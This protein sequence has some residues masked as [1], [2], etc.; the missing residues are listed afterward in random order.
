M[1]RHANQ[2]TPLYFDEVD[3][4]ATQIW[5]AFYPLSLFQ[6]LTN[7]DDPEKLAQRLLLQGQFYL[8]DQID[9]HTL[10]FSGTAIGLK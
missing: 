3:R 6:A 10:F 4:N 5:F 8:K 7:S 9:R 2:L 1:V